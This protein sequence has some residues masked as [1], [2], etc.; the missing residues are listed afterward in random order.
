MMNKQNIYKGKII[1]HFQ[2]TII[3]KNNLI[4]LRG[5]DKSCLA[6][7]IRRVSRFQIISINEVK[8]QYPERSSKNKI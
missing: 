2:Y 8:I 3:Q 6:P 7:L 4:L 1:Y 5:R